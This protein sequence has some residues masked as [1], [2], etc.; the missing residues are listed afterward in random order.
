MNQIVL[1]VFYHVDPSDVWKQSGSFGD[2]FANHKINVDE[3]KVK[4][5]R[6]AMTDAGNLGGWHGMEQVE[7]ISYDLSRSKDMQVNRKVYENM[8]KLRFLKLYW[9]NY[10]GSMTKTYKV[11]LPKDFEFPSQELRY[12]YWDRYPLQT[13]PSEFNGE[14]LVELHMRNSTLKQLWKGRKVLGKLKIIALRDS[15]LLTKMPELSSMPNLE[16]LDLEDCKR[17]KKF[18]EISGNMERL[19]KIDLSGSRIKEIPS[20][21]EYLP[22]LE[23]LT[24][25]YC[26]NFDKFPDNF[27]NLRHLRN[28]RVENCNIKELP[29]SF[30]YLES[31]QNLCLNDCSNLE[32]FPEI[33]VTMKRLRQLLLRGTAI[34]ELPNE[35][36]C[37]EA[38]ICLDLSD[39]SN[40]EEF[41]EIK[42]WGSLRYLSLNNTAIREL[43][44]SIGH[45]TKLYDLNLGNCKNLRS[46]PNSICGLKSLGFLNL[47][48]CSN[49]VAFQEIKEDMEHLKSLYLSETPITELPPSIEHLKGLERLELNNCE[50][51]VTLPNSIGN[52]THLSSLLLRNCSKLHNL[53]DNLR[54]LQCCLR[55]LD[56]AGCNLMEGAVPSDLWCLSSLEFLDDE[57]H[58]QK[59]EE[60][61]ELPSR[62]DILEAHGCPRLT[63]STPSSP[64]WSSLLNLFRSRIQS[65]KYEI[66]SNSIQYFQ[67]PMVVIPGSG[68]IPEWISHQSMGCQAI[69]ELPK[70]RYEDNNFLGFAVFFHYGP[71]DHFRSHR[72][73]RS[74]QFE[75]RISHDDQ[76]ERHIGSSI[77]GDI[78]P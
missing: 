15:Q 41:P 18:P 21:I 12:L 35:F 67:V 77:V 75:L 19:K 58:C 78:F 14:N 23:D 56:L 34:K 37:L 68:G 42:N 66:D 4:R 31:L 26:R 2:A 44:C 74:V 40:F 5:W 39:C 60:I 33:H 46:L 25:D 65:C 32:N 29:N 76:S 6:A 24:L 69:I 36:G 54:S 48:G 9:E 11:F 64:L 22:A 20:S 28:I 49:L 16:V 27:G 62:L 61:S 73:C 71:P 30:G 7:G 8:K 47:N 70:N 63:L 1:P 59:L 57:S 38:L 52:L 45:L 72:I 51:L 13:L 3:E 50:N 55:N 17:L 10:H 43:P 53:P